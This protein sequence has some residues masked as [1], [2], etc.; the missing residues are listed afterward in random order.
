MKVIG[1]MSQ[2]E[3][4]ETLKTFKTSDRPEHRI[5]ILSSIG[6]A[7]LNLHEAQFMVILVRLFY[8]AVCTS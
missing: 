7:G 4:E 2:S 6:A 1:E 3:R 5:L 8:C